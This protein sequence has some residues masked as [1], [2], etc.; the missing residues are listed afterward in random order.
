MILPGH[1]FT[2]VALASSLLAGSA[3]GDDSKPPAEPL[4][5]FREFV[6]KTLTFLRNSG[7][8]LPDQAASLGQLDSAV[9]PIA[10]VDSIADH[11][12][13]TDANV[14]CSTANL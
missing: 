8:D 14:A 11:S 1:W 12:I 10:Q 2:T 5:G 6:T 13:V 7:V 3:R 4:A 9:L